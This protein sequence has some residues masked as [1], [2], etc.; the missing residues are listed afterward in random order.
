MKGLRKSNL[1][2]NSHFQGLKIRSKELGRK[3]KGL[4]K[5]SKVKVFSLIF[6]NKEV[7]YHKINQ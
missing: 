5:S 7:V 2:F 4:A 6:T 3:I 1:K